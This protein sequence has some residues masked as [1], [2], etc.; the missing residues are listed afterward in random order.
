[1]V[2][3]HKLFYRCCFVQP[4]TQNSTRALISVEAACVSK[5]VRDS[6][7]RGVPSFLRFCFGILGVPSRGVPSFFYVLPNLASEFFLGGGGLPSFFLFSQIWP[8]NFSG[9]GGFQAGGVPSFATSGLRIFCHV[10]E[11]G[12]PPLH[13]QQ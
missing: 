4:R 11:G 7:G 12:P 13:L 9:G 6:R 10:E 2:K 8:Q 1:M 5:Q 3:G